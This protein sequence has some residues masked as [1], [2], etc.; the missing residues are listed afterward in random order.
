[1]KSSTFITIL[2]K[3]VQEEL[4]QVFGDSDRPCTLEDAGQLKYL[5]CCIKESLRLY[6]PV[7]VIMRYIKEDTELGG[8]QIPAGVSISMN[9]FALHRNEEYFP[10]PLTF[11]PDRFL[12]EESIGRHP[13]AYIPFSAGP[14]NC[15]GIAFRQHS[16][17][18]ILMFNLCFNRSKI[19][20]VGRES[21]GID[22]TAEI[23]LHVRFCKTRTSKN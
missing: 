10:D 14:R 23:S 8:Y 21:L 22:L 4:D 13:F 6:P 15:I 2:Q 9:I 19:R 3:L 11:R 5:E 1:M 17:G 7:P 20:Y 18:L 16:S 12:N